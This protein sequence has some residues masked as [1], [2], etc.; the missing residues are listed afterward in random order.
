MTNP[1]AESS[2]T[3]QGPLPLE[4]ESTDAGKPGADENAA[5]FLKQAEDEDDDPVGDGGSEA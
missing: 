5:G 3:P 1:K 2:K 4:G